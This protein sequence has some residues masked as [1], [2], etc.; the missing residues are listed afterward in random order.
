M[1]TIL[2]NITDKLNI[3]SDEDGK[4]TSEQVNIM[5]DKVEGEFFTNWACSFLG[6]IHSVAS[7][8]NSDD[9]VIF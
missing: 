9:L 7:E 6:N 3:T 2:P 1:N 5:S 4:N 8:K